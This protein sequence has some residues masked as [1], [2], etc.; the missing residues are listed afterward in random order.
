ME[1]KLPPHLASTSLFYRSLDSPPSLLLLLS[2]SHSHSLL[3]EESVRPSVR[4]SALGFLHSA[5]TTAR[6]RLSLSS[7]LHFTD[8]GSIIKDRSIGHCTALSTS[9][10]R[11][12]RSF[13]GSR[14]CQSIY[15]PCHYYCFVSQL[16]H[17]HHVLHLYPRVLNVD[18]LADV[19]VAR[20]RH[21]DAGRACRGRG[22][23][24]A[25]KCDKNKIGFAIARRRLLFPRWEMRSGKGGKG[26]R[27]RQ[28]KGNARQGA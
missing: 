20:R 26:E 23:E 10:V 17:L 8:C 5:H 3:K 14:S 18:R 6:A 22:K 11:S 25:N 27:Q 7:P 4:Y 24:I 12:F 19:V 21:D 13:F 28:G 1:W 9:F 16:L 2:S 15:H